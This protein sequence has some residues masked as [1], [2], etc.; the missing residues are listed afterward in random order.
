MLVDPSLGI[1][2]LWLPYG[3][4]LTTCH[5]CIVSAGVPGGPEDRGEI[6]MVTDLPF[7]YSVYTVCSG[8][9]PWSWRATG[10]AGI[11]SNPI[12][13]THLIQLIKLMIS[14]LI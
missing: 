11:C 9:H 3:G 6:I 8:F 13:A 1:R 2:C 14:G 5:S 4:N 10:C 7:M 12:A